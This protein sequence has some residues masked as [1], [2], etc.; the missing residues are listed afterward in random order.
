MISVYIDVLIL[1]EKIYPPDVLSTFY[2]SDIL[3]VS[4]IAD[5]ST[6]ISISSST[7]YLNINV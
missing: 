6:I 1:L 3:R 4:V 5:M 7:V 2:M